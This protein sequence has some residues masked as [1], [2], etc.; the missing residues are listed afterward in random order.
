MVWGMDEVVLSSETINANASNLLFQVVR[1]ILRVA[2]S[3]HYQAIV[4]LLSLLLKMRSTL[5]SDLWQPQ[6]S[7]LP[8]FLPGA[9]GVI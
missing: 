9:A 5:A 2:S 4:M 1:N 6:V 3:I 7:Q 8:I